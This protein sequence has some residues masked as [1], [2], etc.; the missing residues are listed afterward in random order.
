M[1]GKAIDH[2][3]AQRW[4]GQRRLRREDP[5][6]LTGW[7]R[8]CADLARVDTCHVG[9][10]RSTEAHADIVAVDTEAAR[11]LPG[12]VGV[13]LAGDLHHELPPQPSTH[14]L[15]NRPTPYFALAVGRV[16]HVG[17]AIAAVVATS[18]TALADALGAVEVTYR[19]RPAVVDTIEALESPAAMLFEDWP[20]NVAA[21]FESVMGDPDAAID[22]ADVVVRARL[23]VQR[24]I[25]ASMEGR[26]V[27]AEWDPYR[28]ELSVWTST[29]SP[30]IVRDFLAEVT[31]VPTARVKVRVPQV[32]GGFG[33]KF[34]FYAEESAVALLAIKLRRSVMWTE[35]RSESFV[36]TVHA[37]EMVVDATIAARRDGTITAITGDIVADQG[38][39]MHM[40][41]FGP[42]WLTAVM[43]TNTYAIANARATMR[44]V[45]TNKTPTGSYRGWGQPEANFVVERMVDLLSRQLDL[46]G[47]ELRR[48]NLVRPEA[49]PYTSLFHT[50]DSGDYPSALEAG[51]ALG[52]VDFWRQAQAERR[53]RH[54][55][56]QLGIGLSFWVENTALGPSRTMNAGG[57]NQGGFDISKVRLEPN[58]D[59]TVY[60]GLCEMG[61]GFTNGLASMCA[62][63]LGVHV[64]AVTVVTGDTDACPYT[65]HGTGASRSASIGGAAVR[66]AALALQDRIRPIAAHMLECAEADL[67]FRDGVISVVGTPA[68]A[69]TMA[70]IGRAAYLRAIELPPDLDPGLEVTETFDPENCA[71]PYGLTVAVVEVDT[72]TAL[73]RVVDLSVFHDCGTVLN[74]MIVEGQLHGGATQGIAAALMEELRYDADGQPLNANFMNFLIPSAVEVPNF[75]L[76]H[77]TTPSPIIPGGMKGIGEA[78]I[79]GPPAAV[80]GAIDDALAPFG[81]AAF[82][83]TPVT[84][85]QIFEALRAAR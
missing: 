39:Y 60:T 46:D 20:D 66:K 74:P 16:R 19:G 75:R 41:S 11:A 76:D 55:C 71:W 13:F 53:Q 59:V 48:R 17:E 7:A 58:G 70:D 10:V 30:H 35:T 3:V 78:G 57:L 67:R 61:Q 80:L 25:G 2:E 63:A 34:H 28:R 29:Q 49:M 45:V 4:V 6:L 33:S 8:Y 40:V 73:V 36:A 9:F 54:D 52:R 68:R 18:A 22:Q 1:A 64:D 82:L 24:Q 42:A 21:T 69:V 47:V 72:E 37:R 65:G 84:P 23:G 79:I 43:M 14:A 50:F 83:S 32:G 15:G 51:V 62:D 31:G 38:A 56:R 12:V 77:M 85:Q 26:G 81:V 27:L 5:A 44:A